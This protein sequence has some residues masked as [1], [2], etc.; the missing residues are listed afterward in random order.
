[1]PSVQA[2]GGNG[3]EPRVVGGLIPARAPVPFRGQRVGSVRFRVQQSGHDAEHGSA[4]TQAVMEAQY[5]GRFPRH[6][7]DQ[8]HLP[9]RLVQVGSAAG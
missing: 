1:M 4:V 8:V 6:V 9:D 3:Y 5:Y 2:P 7:V